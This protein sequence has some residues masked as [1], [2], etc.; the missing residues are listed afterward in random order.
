MFVSV[1]RS[2]IS[3]VRRLTSD[4]NEHTYGMWRMIICEFNMEY[5]I[6]RFQKNNLRLES[7]FESDISISI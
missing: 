2:E 4:T 3:K 1:S 7:I 5:L 6:K